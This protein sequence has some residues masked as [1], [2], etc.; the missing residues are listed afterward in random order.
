MEKTKTHY[1]YII[2]GAGAAG[3]MLAK[4]MGNDGFFNSKSILLLDKDAKSTN[5]RT[6]CYWE[7]GTGHFDT[8]V[9]KSWNS[10]FFG[11]Q[12]FSNQLNIAPYTYKLIRGIDFYRSFIEKI[13][14]YSNVE[15]VKTKVLHHEEKDNRVIVRTEETT[16]SCEQL[17]N[18]IFDIESVR[19]NKKY[20][21]LQQHFIGWSIKS[22]EPIFEP[23]QATFMDFSIE[24]KN[25][26]RF[27]YVLPFSKNT[28]LIEYTLFSEHLLPKKEYE[29]AIREYLTKKL[30]CTTFEIL[31]QEKGSIPMTC[32]K[33]HEHNTKRIQYIGTAGGWSKPSTGYTFYN[34]SKNTRKIVQLLKEGKSISKVASKKKFWFYDLLLLDILYKHNNKGQYIFETLFKNRPPQLI[35][36]FLDEETNF[37]EDLRIIS[38]C[39]KKEFL[40]ACLERVLRGFK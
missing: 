2:I 10:I 25:N 16:Y 17:F 19:K 22:Q 31:E 15:F 28:A 14:S 20:P 33:F 27:M 8:I 32:Y 13:K 18:S 21:V 26:T 11:G 12:E 3:L 34:T 29:D 5:D 4:A 6:W 36:K 35:F 9:H 38:G 37:W 1:D 39:P 24:Q 30:G 7:K 23:S 40:N